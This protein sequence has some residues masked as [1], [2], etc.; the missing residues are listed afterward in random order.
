MFKS[1]LASLILLSSSV[2][3]AQ[4]STDYHQMPYGQ[5]RTY[6]N[7]ELS[8]INGHQVVFVS[9]TNHAIAYDLVDFVCPFLLTAENHKLTQTARSVNLQLQGRIDGDKWKYDLTFIME[10][11]Y[12]DM[13]VLTRIKTSKVPQTKDLHDS[14][15]ETRNKIVDSL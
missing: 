14:L 8:S 7:L 2:M 4:L 10:R 6:C 5:E 9:E 13:F 1:M 15:I 12:N 3:A 11:K